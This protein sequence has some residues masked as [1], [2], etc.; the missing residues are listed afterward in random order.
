[1]S[2]IKKFVQSNT[3]ALIDTTDEEVVE[4]YCKNS[5]LQK[6]YALVKIFN[7]VIGREIS[8]YNF[9]IIVKIRI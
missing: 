7:K 1:M 9:K 3:Q 5:M 6:L 8:V 4:I 2:K